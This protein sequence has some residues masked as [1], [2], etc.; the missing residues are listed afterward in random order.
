MNIIRFGTSIIALLIVTETYAMDPNDFD[1][2][3]SCP[4]SQLEDLSYRMNV[5]M[6]KSCIYCFPKF[7][8]SHA[9]YIIPVCERV[10]GDPSNTP[11][12]IAS[13]HVHRG[14]AW[15]Q[16]GY[17]FKADEDFQIALGI[18]DLEGYSVLMKEVQAEVFHHIATHPL[19]PQKMRI[20]YL[21]NKPEE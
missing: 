10:L 8:N 6:L 18:K 16:L 7:D 17:R 9:K 21:L 2:E 14:A 20:D 11:E 12:E 13:I 19:P 5:I 1:P 15:H 3:V 4:R